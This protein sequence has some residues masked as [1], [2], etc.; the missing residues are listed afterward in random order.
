MALHLVRHAK[1]GN[2]STWQGD[3]E[4]RPLTPAG[5]RQAVTVSR[6]LSEWPVDRVL[7]S[8]YAR[9]IET[10][11][12]T[13]TTL[14]LA[15]EP[16][17]ALAEEAPLEATWALV[18][19]LAGGGTNAVLCSHGNVLSA[20]LDRVHRRGVDV[21]AVEWT[22]HKASVWRLETDETGSLVKAVLALPQA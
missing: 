8:R 10:V 18:E 12:P 16:H 4:L 19:E 20:V 9:C 6:V 21:D 11:A 15:V 7:S 5:Q 14:A 17:D 1:A 2:A 13:A 3:D 22:C